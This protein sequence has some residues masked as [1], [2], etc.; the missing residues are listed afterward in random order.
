MQD[1][2]QT[3]D[4]TAQGEIAW[5][6]EQLQ[7]S[8]S[9]LAEAEQ[10]ITAIRSGEVDAVVVSGP[11]GDQI[12]TLQGA[13]YA[14]RA[15]VEEMSE[16][17]ATLGADGAIL[18]CNQRLSDLMHRP[19]EQIIG[20]DVLRL[21]SG[22]QQETFKALFAEARAGRAGST[23][24]E[25]QADDMTAAPVH[26]SLRAMTSLE[27][28]T[29]CMVVTDLK[30]RKRNEE[31]LAA[32]RLA[33]TILDSAAEAIAVC[34]QDGIII[35]S[36]EAFRILCNCNPVF[37]R[38][39]KVMPFDEGDHPETAG[40]S[41][42]RALEGS[43]IRAREVTICHS[44]SQPTHLLLSAS[45]IRSDSTVIGCVCSMTDVT[46][47]KRA[48]AAV[49]RNE[50]LASVGR[51]ASTI[52]HEINNPLE[53]IGQSIYLAMTDPIISEEAKSYLDLAVIELERVALI[54]KQTLAFHRDNSTAKEIDLRELTESVLKFFTPRLIARGVTVEKRFAGGSY[55]EALSGEIRQVVS[56]LLSNSMDAVPNYGRILIRT[57][58]MTTWQGK[59]LV[60]LSIADNG[61][62]I[63]PSSLKTIFE[64]FFTTKEIIGTGLGLWVTKQIV[65]KHGA[66]IRVR[67]KPGA[68]TVFTI[69]FPAAAQKIPRE[70]HA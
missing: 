28:L 20:A 42:G 56:N 52:A 44:D 40:F 60:R 17:A 14:Y 8:Q 37:Q 65:E 32:G 66:E 21:L 1:Q 64:P 26:V 18:Y 51:M 67:S 38:F 12:F 10:I 69:G 13:E 63:R 39:E 5:R 2:R 35:R 68:G 41:V 33:T 34:D 55:I 50:K 45:P 43:V 47:G 49:L 29:V 48:Q 16:G 59:R 9:R 30:D 15:L 11:E 4:S 57:S 25:L 3:R 22:E 58:C 27:P 46:E 31:Q 23:E 54:T 6:R 24:L 62:G 36:N 61:S 53:I 7:A 70:S 19:M